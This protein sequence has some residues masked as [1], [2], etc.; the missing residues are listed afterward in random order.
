MRVTLPSIRIG[1]QPNRIEPLTQELHGAIIP[2]RGKLSWPWRRGDRVASRQSRAA[3]EF[4]FCF[5]GKALLAIDGSQHAMEIGFLGR[6]LNGLFEFRLS[7]RELLHAS[8][9]FP[10]QFVC[11]RLVR[12]YFNYLEKIGNGFLIAILVQEKI[13]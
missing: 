11:S 13:P 7:L 9:G 5:V 8:V 3:V 4:N 6:E 12:S 1:C 2:T 10:Q